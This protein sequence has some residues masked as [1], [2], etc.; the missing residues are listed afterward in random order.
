MPTRKPADSIVVE[1]RDKPLS[2]AERRELRRHAMLRYQKH[3]QQNLLAQP[4]V[5]DMI[6]VLDHLKAGFNVA[7]IFR[8]AEFMGAHEIHLIG[9]EPFDPAPAKGGFK[10]VPACFFDDFQASHAD[11][12][13]RGYALFALEPGEECRRLLTAPLPRRSAFIFGHEEL[14]ITFERE[15][16]PGIRCL[17]IPGFGSTE[18]LNVGVAA[19]I[20]MY[21][22]VTQH[23]KSIHPI[24]ES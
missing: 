19:A 5:H 22:Y 1:T 3:R 4:G 16:F 15:R 17:S 8:S 14:G 10:K 7:K 9:I 23:S 18:S 20:V 24:I 21:E 11:L 13:A 12:S 2:R 6:L